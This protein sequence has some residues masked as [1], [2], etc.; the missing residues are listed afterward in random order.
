MVIWQYARPLD[1][2]PDMLYV[3]KGYYWITLLALWPLRSVLPNLLKGIDPSPCSPEIDDFAMF[4]FRMQM[5][6]FVLRGL[7]I[8]LEALLGN[9]RPSVN[10]FAH[11]VVMQL[12]AYF[13]LPDPARARHET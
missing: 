11:A 7:E 2:W 9:H 1:Y 10:G 4:M 3:I 5:F 8:A 13:P 6:V 12:V